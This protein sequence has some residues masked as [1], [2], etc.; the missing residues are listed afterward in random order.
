MLDARQGIIATI[1]AA[2]LWAP[3]AQAATLA[4]D[5]DRADCPGAQ[6]TSVQ[7]AIDAAAPGDTVAV[8]PGTYREGSGQPGTNALTITK[9]LTLRGAGAALVRIRPTATPAARIAEDTMDLRNGVGD[10]VA[11]VG[12]P[13]A[14]VDVTISGI[15]V[16]GGGIY[17]EA[18]VVFADAQGA[19]RRTLVTNVVT[20]EQADANGKPGGWRSA[21][22]GV[23]IA[24]VATAPGAARPLLIDHT[25]VEK[26]NSAGIVLQGA[27]SNGTLTGDQIVGRTVC[28]NYEADGNCSSPA[29]ESAGPLFGQDGVRVVG[30][31]T[32]ALTDDTVSQNLVQG[33][34]APVAGSPQNNS[35]L[36]LGAGVRLTDAG[37]ASITHTNIVDNAYGVLAD[38]ATPTVAA[39]DNWWGLWA[40]APANGGPQISPPSN[41]NAPENPVNGQPT[42]DA[43][44]GMTSTAVDFY[45][46]RSGSQ[47]DPNAGEWPVVNAPGAA[48]DADPTVAL[49]SDRAAYDPGDVVGLDA[50][51]G[52]D[53]GVKRVTF[54]DGDAELTTVTAPPWR[55]AALIPAD[56]GCAAR[57][58]GVEAEDSAGQTTDGAI[59]VPLCAAADGRGTLQAGAPTAGSGTGP[60]Q[61]PAT[62]GR[63][64]KRRTH[65]TLRLRRHGRRADVRGVVFAGAHKSGARACG[66]GIVA[67]RFVRHGRT[68]LA[69]RARLDRHCAYHVRARVP[70]RGGYTVRVRFL[71]T[72]AL[73]PSS[74][75]TAV[76]A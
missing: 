59:T 45:P 54:Y 66:G 70:G 44:G 47:S 30:G 51:A 60:V 41:P 75:G 13:A 35:N 33:S 40:T 46:Y 23:G 65:V 61:R 18:G 34:G 10:V 24:H 36:S 20:S 14:P 39:E 27:G 49:T 1:V 17:V 19:V 37:N 21:F 31:A 53:F 7:A 15:T 56:A 57:M 25:R 5:D 52:D 43:A 62:V 55:A 29:I 4:V 64:A 32:A 28:I 69:R 9:S 74:A 67:V 63:R 68:L 72:A 2:A 50:G 26:Y 16:D 12:S 58:Y 38:G 11:V 22:P 42:A 73:R 71:G 48:G 3:A 76:R 8:C 6:Y